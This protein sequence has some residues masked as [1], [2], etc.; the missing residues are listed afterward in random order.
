MPISAD[1][2][3][4]AE[5]LI[6]NNGNRTA[7]A[8]EL[9]ISTRTLQKWVPRL[10]EIGY[11]IPDSE[12]NIDR[13]AYLLKQAMAGHKAAPD[14]YYVKGVSTLYDGQGEVSAQW[15]KTNADEERRDAAVREAYKAMAEGVE[16]LPPIPAP[17][18]VLS[19]LANLYTITDAHVGMHAWGKQTGQDWDLQIAE[20][21]ITGVFLQ[22]IASSPPA[23]VGIVNQLGD[24]LHFDSIKPVTPTSGHILDADSRYQKMAAVGCKVLR[25]IIV[26]AAAKHEVV[27]IIISDDNHSPVGAVWQRLMFSAIF[28]REP[29]VT[30]EMSPSPFV[31]YQHGKTMLGF[32]HGHKVKKPSLPLL[33]AARFPQEWGA[34]RYRYIH[35]GH[36]HHSDEKE[37]PGVY[38]I[39]HPTLAAQDSYAHDMGFESKQ[40]ASSISYHVEHG[41]VGRQTFVPEALA[42]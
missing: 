19:N 39:Q 22:M 17:Q 37:H 16:R 23:R 18:H 27:H 33:F 3:A 26:A 14:G 11:E 40:A 13:T 32:H 15:V 41:Q 1:P 12:Y 20:Q 28:E 21:I 4:M 42:A 6:R 30:V 7:A 38:V 29:R 25:R 24:Y 35:T 10:K 34:S 36:L 9:G 8:E 5:A 31:V 2:K